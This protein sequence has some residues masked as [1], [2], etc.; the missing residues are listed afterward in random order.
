MIVMRLW[1]LF[2]S[3]LVAL[4]MRAQP[5]KLP[6]AFSHSC[7]LPP[8]DSVDV[9]G[10]GVPDLLVRGVPGESTCDIPVS[11]GN[12]EVV[13]Q[14]LP[15]TLLLGSLLPTGGREVHGFAPGDTIPVPHVG[16]QDDLRIPRLA[17]IEGAVHALHWSYGRSGVAPPRMAPQADRVFVFA[18]T[19]GERIVH[20][21]F[22]LELL[23]EQRTVRVIPGM[24]QVSNEPMIVQ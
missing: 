6:F 12:C 16:V 5:G 2:F 8:S 19:A 7:Q 22:T 4:G 15:G 23:V 3:A 11:L 17:Y 9:T 18:T 20:G 10:D 13:V 14:T 1:F 24:L 21:T